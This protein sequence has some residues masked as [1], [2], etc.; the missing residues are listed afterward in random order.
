MKVKP[1]VLW[2]IKFFHKNIAI[3]EFY[4]VFGFCDIFSLK[5]R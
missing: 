2:A 3:E 4:N 1:S 5:H